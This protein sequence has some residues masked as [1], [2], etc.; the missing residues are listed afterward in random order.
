M[1]FITDTTL[2]SLCYCDMFRPSKGYLQGTRLIHFHSKINKICKTCQIQFS[3]HHVLSYV[4][5]V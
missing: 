2:L 5:I 1:H 3:K 4:K